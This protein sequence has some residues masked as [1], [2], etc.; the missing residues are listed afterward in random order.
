MLIS[1]PVMARSQGINATLFVFLAVGCAPEAAGGS[2]V[3]AGRADATLVAA[4]APGAT[5]SCYPG[6]QSDVGRGPC[7]AGQQT[8]QSDS[9]GSGYW[10]S[11]AGA[12]TPAPEIC[13]DGIDNDCDGLIDDC[14]DAG[15]STDAD[16][17]SQNTIMVQIP[18]R[19]CQ[20]VTCPQDHPYPVGCNI[21]FHGDNPRGCIASAPASPTVYFQEGQDCGDG[22]V[23]GYLLCSSVPGAGINQ[24]TC[25][26]NKTN[27]F[28]P[29][30]RYGCPRT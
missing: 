25:P 15:V 21:Q 2:S 16:P 14:Y 11:C 20:Y 29:L 10:G 7:K 4:C 6:N 23:R 27:K 30:D 8:C 9:S 26:M 13:G 5:Q 19:D 18:D 24:T 28:Y 17:S 22:G 3:D 1:S 12:V